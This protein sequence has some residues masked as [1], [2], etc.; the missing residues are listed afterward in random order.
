MG[1]FLNEIPN[2]DKI[3]QEVNDDPDLPTFKRTTFYKL[4]KSLNFKFE[5]RE[6]K[7]ILMDRDEIVIQRSNYL[8]QI[9]RYRNEKKK[10]YYLDETWIN[11]EHIKP[12]IWVD[13]TIKS[14]KQAFLD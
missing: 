13:K 6:R 8:T 12:K 11:A 10:I 3:L 7:S 5:K 4:L 9:R 1:F 2:I 14:T